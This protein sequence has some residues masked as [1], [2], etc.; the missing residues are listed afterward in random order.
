MADRPAFEE[1]ARQIRQAADP[2][3]IA[4]ALDHLRGTYIAKPM[5]YGLGILRSWVMHDHWCEVKVNLKEFANSR[6]TCVLP[7]PC[8]HMI[9]VFARAYEPLGSPS[10]ILGSARPVGRSSRGSTSAPK[11]KLAM[12]RAEDGPETWLAFLEEAWQSGFNPENPSG[13]LATL[14]NRVMPVARTWPPMPAAAWMF[15][16]SLFLVGKVLEEVSQHEENN[17][18]WSWMMGPWWGIRYQ[19]L[20]DLSNRIQRWPQVGN[21][22]RL[23]EPW[24]SFLEELAR[25]HVIVYADF[26]P[27]IVGAYQLLWQS[28]FP[29]EHQESECAAWT[30]LFNEHPNLFAE[31]MTGFAYAFILVLT[32]RVDQARDIVGGGV[33]KKALP[34]VVNILQ[35]LDQERDASQVLWWAHRAWSSVTCENPWYDAIVWYWSQVADSFD[36]E[37]QRLEKELEEGLPTNQRSVL[38]YLF[39]QKRIGSALDLCMALDIYPETINPELLEDLW[40]SHA[41]FMLSWYHQSAEKLVSLKTRTAYASAAVL[42]TKIRSHYKDVGQRARWDTFLKQFSSRH[43]RLKALEK[44]LRSKRIVMSS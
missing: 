22:A 10:S 20:N 30:R 7:K 2:D 8:E 23:P 44:A 13:S 26:E 39:D 14:N 6:C 3:V 1:C 24:S 33:D 34:Y 36:G 21:G 29:P 27:H 11:R 19:T 31:S 28:V 16:V 17:N 25:H 41:D 43:K 4:R 5:P 42:L 18:P 12:P 38:Q 35:A 9:A 40:E 37:R 32:R 15:A